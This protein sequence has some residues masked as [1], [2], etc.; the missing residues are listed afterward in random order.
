MID[1]ELPIDRTVCSEMVRKFFEESKIT[2]ASMTNGCSVNLNA[3]LHDVNSDMALN[4]KVYQ[5]DDA[6][7]RARREKTVYKI[8]K[9]RTKV[10][11]PFILSAEYPTESGNVA[12]ALRPVLRGMT[13]EDVRD[14]LSSSQQIALSEQLGEYMAQIHSVSFDSFGEGIESGGSF[15]EWKECLL[16]LM[17]R[18]IRT[19]RKS[20]VVDRQTARSV[21]NYFKTYEYLL[22]GITPAL[23]HRDIHPG[24]I[25]LEK[26]RNGWKIS[27]IYDFEHAL[28]G[29]NE[30]DFA[31]PHWSLSNGYGNLW[32]A[33]LRTYKSAYGLSQ[34]FKQRL[35]GVY[36]LAEIVDF[37]EFG[38]KMSLYADVNRGIDDMKVILRGK[39]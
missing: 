27:G 39:S 2:G 6:N 28:A 9:S 3:Q 29:H 17:E 22:D 1:Y 14:Q 21:M 12:F 34:E 24:N 26:T 37:L 11:V 38:V 20:G 36:K 10:P 4:L 25:Q 33:L 13:M 19:C 5:G 32:E 8:I 30:F 23:V 16:D 35:E 7:K 18:R 15:T 31:K